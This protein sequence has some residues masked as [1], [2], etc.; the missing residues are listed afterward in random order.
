MQIS[1]PPGSLMIPF[2]ILTVIGVLGV[3]FIV[4]Y[5][6]GGNLLFHGMDVLCLISP[7]EPFVEG[8]V[9]VLNRDPVYAIAQWGSNALF[10]VGFYQS[11]R[12]FDRKVK[13][14]RVMYRWEYSHPIGEIKVA[15]REGDFIIPVERGAYY[16][17]KGVLYSLLLEKKLIVTIRKDFTAEQLNLIVESLAQELAAIGSGS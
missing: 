4:Y 5:R 16:K 15:R 7:P 13:V 3:L 11:E 8:K 17:G 14:P 12:T 10:F 2:T 1:L 9:A 6:T